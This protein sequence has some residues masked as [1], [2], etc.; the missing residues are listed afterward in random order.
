MDITHIKL[1]IKNYIK[2][3]VFLSTVYF[4]YKIFKFTIQGKSLNKNKILTNKIQSKGV[5]SYKRT[6]QIII[7]LTSYPARINDSYFTI[8]SLLSQSL[9]PD[10]IILW[11]SLEEFPEKN[12]S[13]PK[14]LIELEQFGLTIGWIPKTYYSFDKIIHALKKFPNDILVTA[15][16]DIFYHKDW[17]KNLYNSYKN[18]KY[19]NIIICH[20]MHKI[21][22]KNG[23]PIPYNAWQHEIQNDKLDP[24]NFP[25]GCG[26]VLYPPHCF[27]KDV[28]KEDIFTNT[29][30]FA[31]DIWLWGMAL[32][33][34]CFF[35]TAKNCCSFKYTNIYNECNSHNK[36]NLKY[37]NITMNNNDIQLYKLLQQYPKLLKIINKAF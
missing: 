19:R 17:L 7:T 26:G 2:N 1:F 35:I 9:K 29:T 22:L 20:R 27:Y 15:D 28:C 5:N 36:Q 4:Y 3:S 32:L 31:D 34:N 16:D 6:P 8:Y 33:N 24:L 11:L 10:K 25:T 12:N 30:P 37:Y 14:N 21:A 23:L 18:N 13:L